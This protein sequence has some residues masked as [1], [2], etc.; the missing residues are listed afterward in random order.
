MSKKTKTKV[1]HLDVEVEL[2]I[3]EDEIWTY[4]IEGLAAPH[5]NKPFKNATQ[6]KIILVA[7]IVISVTLS[8]YFS[9]MSVVQRGSLEFEDNA[10]GATLV[11][12]TNVDKNP[13]REIDLDYVFTMENGKQIKDE[14]KKITEIRDF[15]FNGEGNVKVINIGADVEKIGDKAFYSCWALE[16]IEVDE[17][18][19][20]YSD[21]DGVL[22]NKDQTV[23]MNYP[24]NHDQYLRVKYGY[25]IPEE[26]KADPVNEKEK[27]DEQNAMYKEPYRGM[28]TEE[29][30]ARLGNADVTIEQY[31]KDIQTYVVPST[32]EVI[33]ELAFAYTNIQEIYLPEGLKK[34]DNMGLFKLHEP[35]S[36]DGNTP[37]LNNIYTYKADGVTDT[38]FTSEEALGEIYLSLPEG[39]EYIGT[40]AVSYNQELGYLYIPESVTYIGH[41]AFWDCVYKQDGEIKGVGFVD[42]AMN[43]ADFEANV[44]TGDQWRPQYDNG[45]FNK[46]ISIN[47]S[48]ERA[49]LD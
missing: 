11:R 14:T 37:S 34:I 32:V 5:I 41:H 3:P 39:L 40:D 13:L 16:R 23:V 29:Y 44:D 21:I 24:C 26:E 20:Y 1:S 49:T 6:K 42:T 25:D 12:Y 45:L 48:A 38:A 27:R 19:P 8:M 2:D 47:Y 35:A 31:R 22:Y 43:E 30:R 36:W 4:K 17:N 18:N 9:I 10:N 28:T 46:S 15:A 7:V 33:N